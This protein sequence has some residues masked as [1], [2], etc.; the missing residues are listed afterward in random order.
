MKIQLLP[1]DLVREINVCQRAIS[2]RTTMPILE[3]IRF[4]AKGKECILRSSDLEL[5][6]ETR[7][8]CQVL[9]EGVTVIPASVVG[10]IFRK[11][12]SEIAVLEANE[13]K[14][15]IDCARSHFELQ[16]PQAEEFPAFPE[17]ET[18]EE[19][20]LPNDM[21]R[22]AVT[23]TEFASSLDDSKIALTGIYFEKKAD[24]VRFVALDGYRLAVRKIPLEK[25]GEGSELSVIIPK[26][27]LS[28]WTRIIDDEE[29]RIR[30]VPGHISFE[31]GSIRMY[32]RLI[33]KQY[34]DYEEIISTEFSTTVTLSRKEFQDALERAS[35]MT[36]EE[37]AN[38]VKLD[39]REGE[40]LIQSNSETGNVRELV[41]IDRQGPDLKIAFNAKY[42]LDGV[43][44][45]DCEK[46]LLYLN[47]MLN[48][49]VMR[50]R[51]DEESYLYL[52]LPVRVARE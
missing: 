4:E 52:V 7:L 15:T 19:L 42:L 27:A 41:S 13:G 1:Q 24:H 48:P 30:T 31:S 38:L 46:L 5:S 33:D 6:I 32:S 23:E 50:P 49:M 3:C 34:I 10:N 20:V 29:T 8:R 25:S 44:A 14:V 36:R 47:G 9:E 37:R 12:S 26:R 16:V 11:L 39:F 2:S 22:H 45:L 40:L 18:Q 28:E 21:V 51:E 35:V 17:L 43:K